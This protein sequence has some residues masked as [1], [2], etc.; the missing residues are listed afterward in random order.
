MEINVVL[1]SGSPRRQ[2]LL[3]YIFNDFTVK[4]SNI[5]EIIPENLNATKIPEYLAEIKAKDIASKF[6][7]SLVI[8]A[9]TVVIVGNTVLGKPKNRAEAYEMLKSLSGTTHKVITGCALLLNGNYRTFSVITEVEF[10]PL[11]EN[12]IEEYIA[13][14]EP[15]DKAGG[16]GIQSKGAL[17]VKGIKGDYFNVVGF[18]IAELKR[19][20]T[21][22]KTANYKIP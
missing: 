11:T 3:K 7:N 4:V 5:E 15:Y 19:Q 14:D 18:P 2:E 9:D 1:A 16:Y 6:P 21:K 20:I 8:G 13:S 10:Y 12:E 17:L 22:I